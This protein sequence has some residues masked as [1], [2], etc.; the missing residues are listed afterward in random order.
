[1]SLER[2]RGSGAPAND[3]GNPKATAIPK[4][5][6][7]ADADRGLEKPLDGDLG[8]YYVMRM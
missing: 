8:R 5:S 1:M 4:R 7:N 3:Q 6:A 2:G